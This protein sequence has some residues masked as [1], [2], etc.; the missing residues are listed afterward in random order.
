VADVG[1]PGW[2]ENALASAVEVDQVFGELGKRFIEEASVDRFGHFM[3]PG[4][5]RVNAVAGEGEPGILL[6]LGL[7]EIV[8]GSVEIDNRFDPV[9][10]FDN[11]GGIRAEDI[12]V[13]VFVDGRP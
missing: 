10:L 3:M 2:R 11:P 8:D 13:I 9:G 12:A 5:V 4:F 6:T 1:H 7:L